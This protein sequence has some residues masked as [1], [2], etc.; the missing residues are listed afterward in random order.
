MHPMSARSAVSRVDVYRADPAVCGLAG[1]PGRGLGFVQG[2]IRT[3]VHR[4]RRGGY[5][6]LPPGPTLEPPPP[7]SVPRGLRLKKFRP[8]V[9]GHQRGTQGGG[10]SQPNPL[11]PFRTPPSPPSP[12]QNPPF[13]PPPPFRT[14]PPPPPFRTPP[15]PPPPPL[16]IHPWV[17]GAGGRCYLGHASSRASAEGIVAPSLWRNAAHDGL[18]AHFTEVVVRSGLRQW[19]A[20]AAACPP[21]VGTWC[22]LAHPR[23]CGDA[24]HAPTHREESLRRD[25]VPGRPEGRHP[26]DDAQTSVRGRQAPWGWRAGA[27][28]RGTASPPLPLPCVRRGMVHTH[29]PG[30]LTHTETQRG[31]L[32]TACGQ[33]RV[34]TAKTV[35]RPRQ[36]PAH[37]Q[38]ANYW[39]LLTRKR[40]TRHIQHSPSTPTTGLRERGNDTSKSTG[41]SC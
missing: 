29:V 5:P 33:R 6:P 31:R 25:A 8:A 18:R 39:A 11:P 30:G 32:W 12:L 21:Y 13:P 35:K 10:V 9:G 16:L 28:Y 15:S 37:P 40:H 38:Y 23:V 22:T 4:R 27:P 34:W 36:Q 7:P 19:T 3:A 1:A 41:C 14:P 17:R 26:A 24:W 2:C 20:E